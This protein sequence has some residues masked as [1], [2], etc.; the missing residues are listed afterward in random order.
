MKPL[1]TWK[2][3]PWKKDALALVPVLTEWEKT[4]KSLQKI[5]DIIQ[6]VFGTDFNGS[7]CKALDAAILH[8]HNLAEIACGDNESKWLQYYASE[9]EFGAKQKCVSLWAGDVFKPL[10][11]LFDLAVILTAPNP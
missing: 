10:K 9:C 1:K 8:A 6:D 2:A 4:S 11:S 5:F 3:A 7:C